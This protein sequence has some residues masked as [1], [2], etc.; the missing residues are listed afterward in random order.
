MVL[1]KR[2]SRMRRK[3]ES[4]RLD[5]VLRAWSVWV[6]QRSAPGTARLSAATMRGH[7][8][9]AAA[10]GRLARPTPRRW[11]QR[12]AQADIPV[13]RLPVLDNGNVRPGAAGRYVRRELVAGRGSKGVEPLG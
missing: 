2:E 11:L 12:I 4:V 10:R 6:L 7:E 1:W 3:G 9:P 13:A 8:R 5:A